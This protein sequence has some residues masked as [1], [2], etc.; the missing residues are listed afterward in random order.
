MLFNCFLIIKGIL[1]ALTSFI[2]WLSN[3]SDLPNN[4]SNS[5][6]RYTLRLLSKCLV[7]ITLLSIGGKVPPTSS[8]TLF[9]SLRWA[10]FSLALRLCSSITK[11]CKTYAKLTPDFKNHRNLDNF[12]QAVESPKSW[13]SMGYICL[14]TTFLHLKHY[15]QICLTLLS[16]DLSFGGIRQIFS[17][18]PKLGFWWDPLTQGWKGRSL[19][20]TEE[21]SV[22]TMKNGT[23]FGEESTWCF[24]IDIRNLTNFD[25]S[26][27][28][29]Q[30]CSL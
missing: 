15:L 8:I 22:M 20:S 24:K 21:L 23:K 19:K 13:N 1:K 6:K 9:D 18:V 16:T 29:F 3:F 17:R 28:K 4:G 26:T 7:R 12:R 10:F 27:R 2:P 11:L 25:L 14:K 30:K 5:G